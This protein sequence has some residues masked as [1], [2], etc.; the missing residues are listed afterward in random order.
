MSTTGGD[1]HSYSLVPNEDSTE[2]ALSLAAGAARDEAVIARIRDEIESLGV[3][4]PLDEGAFERACNQSRGGSDTRDVI[5]VGVPCQHGTDGQLLWAKKLVA[6]KKEE[7]R[8]SHYLGM[9]EKK[10]VRKGDPVAKIVPETDGTDGEDIY[11]KP[12]K[13]RRGKPAKVRVGAGLHEADGIVYAEKEGMIRTENGLMKL[14]E[15]FI[16]DGDVDFKTGNIS[17]PGSVVIG[18]S[19]L[20]LFEIKAGGS[21][22]IKGIVEAA[23]LSAKGDIEIAGG[24]AGKNKGRVMTEGSVAAQFLVNAYVFAE[25]DV[26]VESEI[27]SSKVTALGAVK[28]AECAIAGGHIEALG[29]IYAETLGS[30]IGI[31]T[32]ITAGVCQTLP[33]LIQA[34]AAR[35][36]DARRRLLDLKRALVS[37]GAS[38]TGSGLRLARKEVR[39]I[40]SRL[41]S[42]LVQRKRLALAWQSAR[43]LIVVTR[44]LYPGVTVR[45]GPYSLEINEEITGPVK[46]QPDRKNKR[47]KIL[48]KT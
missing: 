8:V 17:F 32:Q 30:D 3:T 2:L 26:C 23:T 35:I 7:G 42:C 31:R 45:V 41:C 10:I 25:G 38:R 22:Q 12:V 28:A 44:M 47:V 46:I 18:G 36:E 9:L 1:L 39:E 11:G 24:L 48:A 5:V 29:G 15:T 16:V 20:D 13:A 4:A 19:I 37:A 34:N 6:Q 14:D 21:I 27:L 43:P 33:N 40:Q